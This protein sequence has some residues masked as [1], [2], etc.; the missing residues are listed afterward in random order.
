MVKSK[1]P[2]IPE[3]PLIKVMAAGAVLVSKIP[4]AVLL[5]VQWETSKYPVKSAA[6]WLTPIPPDN[7]IAATAALGNVAFMVFYNVLNGQ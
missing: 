5:V 3:S 2:A 4:E 1:S 7:K 6:A